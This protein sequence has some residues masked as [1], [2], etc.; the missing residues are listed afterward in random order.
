LQAAI[1]EEP[2]NPIPNDLEQMFQSHHGLVFRTAY[3]ITGNAADA[4]DVLQTVFLR[5]L[6]R[7]QSGEALQ[8]PESYFR[9][10]AINVSL[11]VVRAGRDSRSVAL[12]EVAPEQLPS[13]RAQPDNRE[14]RQ[15]LRRALA[16]LN[17][18]EAEIFSLRFF[19]DVSNQEIARMLG[20]SQIHVA[21]I[22]HR[23]RARLQKELRSYW[24]EKS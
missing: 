22:L 2:V 17:R 11:D 24:G 13:E 20:M 8:K 4:E 19:E 1:R 6:R 10:A 21:V 12:Q 23:T 7:D 16:C 5:M 3:R 9:R 15:C 18:R 14:L